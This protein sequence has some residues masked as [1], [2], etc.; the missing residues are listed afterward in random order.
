MGVVLIF[1]CCKRWLI[2]IICLIASLYYL[3]CYYINWFLVCCLYFNFKAYYP[4]GL[5]LFID[6]IFDICLWLGFLSD[7]NYL[8]V[9]L[10]LCIQHG[11]ALCLKFFLLILHYICLW[12][13]LKY[14]K[15]LY[16]LAN[17]LILFRKRYHLLY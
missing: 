16:L 9:F 10:N 15:Q 13:I 2:K 17:L 8:I 14:L 12:A 7:I 4:V 3:C 11:L 6:K 1:M 5:T